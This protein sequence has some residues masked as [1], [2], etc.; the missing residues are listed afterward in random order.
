MLVEPQAVRYA[1]NRS[2]VS[3]AAFE[4][5][6][7]SLVPGLPSRAPETTVLF[8]D[9]NANGS[10]DAVWVQANGAVSY[11][12]LFPT[13]PNLL[14]RIT[15]GIGT[16]QEIVYGTAAGQRRESST[17]WTHPLAIAANVVTK[18]DTW[19]TLTGGD[20]GAG[21]HEITL[22]QYRNG[23]YDGVEKQFR[24]FADVTTL[25]PEDA[26]RDDQEAGRTL[27]VFD[28]G[29]T[30]PYLAGLERSRRTFS[31]S[32]AAERE[33]LEERHAYGDCALTGVPNAG[34]AFPVRHLCLTDTTRILKEGA[35]AAEWATTR[36]TYAY[37]GYGNVTLTS[38]LGVVHM[39][40]PEA[41]LACGAC[42][43]PEG[44][45]GAACGPTCTGDEAYQETAYVEP[46][47]GTGN[48]WILGRP[49]TERAFAVAGGM[50]SEKRTHYDGAAFTGLALGQLTRGDAT[51]VTARREMG[52]DATVSL[53]RASY[54]AHGNVIVSLDPL[55]S[56][57]DETTHRRSY[58]YDATAQRVVR[59]DIH[60]VSPEETPYRLRREY[61]YDPAFDT[62]AEATGWM[63]IEGGTNRSARKQT[64]FRYD[65][66][67]RRIA[68]I[69]PGDT[70][71]TPTVEYAWHL[72][73]PASRVV[74]RQR[75]VRGGELDLERVICMDGRGRTY[76]ERTRL[77]AT[78]FQVSGF[79][80]YNARGTAVRTY[81]PYVRA[82]GFCEVV[83]P[84][85]VLY[86]DVR[87][88][89]L[90]REIRRTYPDADEHGTASA[91]ATTF[92]PL[93]TATFDEEDLDTGSAHANTPTI[94]HH[95]GLGR[96]VAVERRLAAG[97]TGA[98]TRASYDGLG[99]LA[100]LVD[101]LGSVK[102]QTHDLLGRVVTIDDPSTGETEVTYDDAG[103]A[104]ARTDA[105]GKTT[106]MAYD[107]VNRT[108]ASWDHADVMGT[109]VR[110]RYDFGGSCA[111]SN[112]THAEGMPIEVSYPL[113]P[114]VVARL[115]GAPRGVDHAGFDARAQPVYTA[116][117]IAGFP[118]VTRTSFDNAGRPMAIVHPDGRE[119][120]QRVDGASRLVSMSD[121]IER[122]EYDGRGL[123]IL[124]ARTNGAIDTWSYDARARVRTR[125]VR[126][127]LGATIVQTDYARDRRG[128]VV[129]LS[130]SAPRAA[131]DRSQGRFTYDAW[132]RLIDANFL[133]G[134]S[135]ALETQS[136]GYDDRD[137]VRRVESSL[138][139]QST[140]HLGALELDV[141]NP[142]AVTTA[143][144]TAYEYD[145][146]GFMTG[147]GELA[148]EW[149]HMGR[150]SRA[151]RGDDEVARF[152]YGAGTSRVARVEGSAITLYVSR[153]YEIRDGVGV[154]YPRFGSRRLA[155]LESTRIAPEILG[156]PAPVGAPDGTVNAADA[157]AANVAQ[158]SAM[159]SR[160]FLR[161]ACRRLLAESPDGDV[162][163]HADHVENLD[164]AIASDGTAR[165]QRRFAHPWG[166]DREAGF[167]DDYGITGQEMIRSVGLVRFEHRWLDARIHRWASADPLFTYTAALSPQTSAE[168]TNRYCY[169]GGNPINVIDPSGLIPDFRGRNTGFNP[170]T[171]ATFAAATRKQPSRGGTVRFG[172]EEGQIPEATIWA[173][174][175]GTLERVS[176]M[177]AH[178][179]GGKIAKGTP[180][181]VSAAEL[182]PGE[183][184]KGVIY[185]A[186][187]LL[188]TCMGGRG[189]ADNLIP[190]TL[191][192]NQMMSGIE[193]TMKMHML[194]ASED[195]EFTY[196]VVVD[197]GNP[198]SRMPTQI[199]VE[200]T[201]PGIRIEQIIR[202]IAVDPRDMD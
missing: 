25:S 163:L 92:A 26:G 111:P 51:R 172:S 75:S 122:M 95:D 118:F 121:V 164:V 79:A 71:Q 151:S 32:G 50:T 119:I 113:D 105:R 102:R 198:T 100:A 86:E 108:L 72:G 52:S 154:L 191:Y 55:G 147:R 202:N 142:T 15:N 156:D 101:P 180:P 61:S 57:T 13:P 186:G 139:A 123:P 87:S 126:P 128:N 138:G 65:E 187:H 106:R 98:R 179:T 36:I 66:F 136:R 1:L 9:M 19:T 46:L 8:A 185:Q 103:N 146:A 177:E 33:L 160:G 39:G 17:Q 47:T 58:T 189:S 112:C 10:Q 194:G 161:S 167:V 125:T 28:V 116:R 91:R 69:R 82:S 144:G 166:E 49:H 201:G 56:P 29:A 7:S 117:T 107:G 60:L 170:A 6:N 37:D 175:A 77:D 85:N 140:V 197:Y 169:A 74:E 23:F 24:G 22:Y 99:R 114:E 190:L 96:S 130:E 150:L 153:D 124:S 35:P 62:V 93:Y 70:E 195:E 104:V 5:I 133:D 88:D 183:L 41:Q 188:A 78:R 42:D 135:T 199:H 155:R 48:K 59:T 196:K 184:R 38:N 30:S 67:G 40:A 18:L 31:G 173:E 3:F 168:A 145:A 2:G 192:A 178:F 81:Q 115:G 193:K 137:A 44:T 11:L 158:G 200:F 149:D 83:P 127:G 54:D 45:F 110:F 21:L 162:S 27:A 76:Q 143:G 109:E 89:A 132:Y 14:A 148:F 16:V 64:G 34:L 4:T 12:E 94:V 176:G 84:T 165:G 97:E 181:E 73:D 152:S 63:V 171:R 174:G 53:S 131:G 68:I 20:N 80:E 90:A 120:V 134:D 182:A 159:E 129:E 157:Y 43:R 141:A